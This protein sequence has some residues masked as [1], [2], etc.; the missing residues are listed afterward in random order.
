MKKI[1]GLHTHRFKDNPEEFNFAEAWEKQNKFGNNLAYLL[2]DRHVQQGYPPTPSD[3]DYV[4]AATVIQWLGSPVGQNFL[5]DLGYERKNM[6]KKLLQ[7]VDDIEREVAASI[8]NGSNTFAALC[9]LVTPN[10]WCV[11]DKALQRLRRKGRITFDT[12]SRI[13]KV[14]DGKEET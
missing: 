11:I 3:R 4:V 6:N 13:W 7:R 1:K 9:K 12:K 2:D 5:R 14:R 10:D 8:K